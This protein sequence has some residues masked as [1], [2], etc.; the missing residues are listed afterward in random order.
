VNN[1]RATQIYGLP[2]TAR[3]FIVE[4]VEHIPE[5]VCP[6]CGCVVTNKQNWEVY[7]SAKDWEE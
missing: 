6:D 2:E 1:M 4:N 5:H 7:N 3:K